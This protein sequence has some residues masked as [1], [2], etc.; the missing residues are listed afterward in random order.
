LKLPGKL[1]WRKEKDRRKY[2]GKKNQKKIKKLAH[3]GG[4]GGGREPPKKM[5]NSDPPNSMVSLKEL[6]R[7]PSHHSLGS[8]TEGDIFGM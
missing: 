2:E 6:I 5:P 3:R 7:L 4:N 8:F 1:N